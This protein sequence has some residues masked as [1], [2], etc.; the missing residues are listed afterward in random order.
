M[1]SALIV[2][3]EPVEMDALEPVIQFAF[4]EDKDTHLF[5]EEPKKEIW[6]MAQHTYNRIS[7]QS[8]M[9]AFS[10]MIQTDKKHLMGFTVVNTEVAPILYSFGI[11]S[12][13]RTRKNLMAWLGSVERLLGKL[14]IVPLYNKNTRAIRFFERNGFKIKQKD[15]EISFLCQ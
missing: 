2:S 14:Y 11:R 5:H 15:N 8:G 3:L 4:A 10:V 7:G 6:R 13:Y 9:Q 12:E 1:E